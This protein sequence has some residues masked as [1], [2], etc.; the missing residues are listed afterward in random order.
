[1]SETPLLEVKNIAKSYGKGK[2]KK[3]VLTNVS[4]SLN[5]G[6][7]LGII[8]ESGCG[9]SVLL[10]L[11]S[12]LEKVDNGQL[13]SSIQNSMYSMLAVSKSLVS[14]LRIMPPQWRFGSGSVPS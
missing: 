3:Q 5:E 11:I 10:N 4:F 12:C 8:G 14:S 7:V 9:K 1:M 13:W 6:E 2:K